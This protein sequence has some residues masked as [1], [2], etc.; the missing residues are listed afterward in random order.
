MDATIQMMLALGREVEQLKGKIDQLEAKLENF[1]T[2]E[3]WNRL[4]RT[5][6][7]LKETIQ[8]QN[9]NDQNL[10]SKVST[11]EKEVQRLMAM[12]EVKLAEAGGVKIDQSTNVDQSTKTEYN[13][14][15]TSGTINQAGEIHKK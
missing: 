1:P 12:A 3:S 8:S 7:N 15:T 5:I 13:A 9:Q 2:S 6:K 11:I 4:V 14:T 10:A